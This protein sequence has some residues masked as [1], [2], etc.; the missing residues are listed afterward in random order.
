MK[1]DLAEK[2]RGS[3]R[4]R[5]SVH[6]DT[7]WWVDRLAGGSTVA[8]QRPAVSAA[9]WQPPEAFSSGRKQQEAPLPS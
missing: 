5:C 4:R 6:G 1:F 7:G 2:V 8:L 3:R 9:S